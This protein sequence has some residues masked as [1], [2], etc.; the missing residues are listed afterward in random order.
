[1]VQQC[2]LRQQSQSVT[3]KKTFSVQNSSCQLQI[4]I[5]TITV[6][7]QKISMYISS[8]KSEQQQS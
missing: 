8:L 7:Y 6:I 1:M 5:K 3:D 4:K 2:S